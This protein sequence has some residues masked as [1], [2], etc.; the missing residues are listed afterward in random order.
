MEVFSISSWTLLGI[1]QIPKPDISATFPGNVRKQ[2]GSDKPF[3]PGGKA[4]ETTQKLVVKSI[5]DKIVD[6]NEKTSLTLI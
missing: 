4:T 1:W 6:V 2:I 3:F 5:T